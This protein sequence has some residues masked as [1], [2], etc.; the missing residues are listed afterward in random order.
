MSECETLDVRGLLCPLPVIR[1]QNEARTRAAGAQIEVLATDPGVLQDIPAW[2]RVHGHE[3]LAA[4]RQDRDIRV[5]VRIC[6][7]P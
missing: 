5:L 4:E 6:R 7:A 1:L 2:C 3:V